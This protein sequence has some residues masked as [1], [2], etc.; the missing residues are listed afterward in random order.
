MATTCGRN[1]N[2]GLPTLDISKVMTVIRIVINRQAALENNVRI[3]ISI[4]DQ[5]CCIAVL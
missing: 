3:W 1:R 5:K 2:V 4:G